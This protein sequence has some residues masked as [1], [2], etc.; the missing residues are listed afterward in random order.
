M[1]SMKDIGAVTKEKTA[2]VIP[3]AIQVTYLSTDVPALHFGLVHF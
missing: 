1:I 3:N 2:K